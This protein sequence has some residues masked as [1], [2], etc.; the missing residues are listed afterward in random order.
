M[1]AFSRAN[2]TKWIERTPNGNKREPECLP[3]Q[4]Y[5]AV[6]SETKFVA[7]SNIEVFIYLA[8][9]TRAGFQT[10]SA[11]IDVVEN[12]DPRPETPF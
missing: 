9:I 1:H 2:P 10:C 11:N 7:V 6:R 3:E 4:K 5:L 8:S 12:A